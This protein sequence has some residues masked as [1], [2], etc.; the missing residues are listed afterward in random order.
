ME[1]KESSDESV[2]ELNPE[3]QTLYINNLNE[4]IKLNDLTHVLE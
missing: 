1:G 2:V 3:N 4:L